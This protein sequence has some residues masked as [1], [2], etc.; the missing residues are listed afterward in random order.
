MPEIM[1]MQVL[2]TRP[3]AHA[4][5]GLAHG[6]G[7]TGRGHGGHREPVGDAIL[8]VGATAADCGFL[9]VFHAADAERW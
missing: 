1:K 3:P 8:L 9:G 2:D 4:L 6:A 7:A 5:P